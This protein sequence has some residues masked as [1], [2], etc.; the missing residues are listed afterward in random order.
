M[1]LGQSQDRKLSQRVFTPQKRCC[2]LCAAPSNAFPVSCCAVS[3]GRPK[4]K[5]SPQM[6]SL[7]PFSSSCHSSHNLARRSRSLDIFQSLDLCSFK[8]QENSFVNIPSV[9]YCPPA[10]T[11]YSNN[12]S[13]SHHHLAVWA[14]GLAAAY[15]RL[16]TH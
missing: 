15:V 3:A 12:Q 6:S 11:N 14:D 1:D 16:G 9:I 4:G 2:E 10:N 13:A 5:F 7:A 8:I